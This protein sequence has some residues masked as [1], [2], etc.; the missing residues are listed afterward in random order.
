M[1]G[2]LLAGEGEGPPVRVRRVARVVRRD[3]EGE[4]PERV[5]VGQR[6]GIGDVEHRAQAAALQL[7]D[8]RVGDDDGAAPGVGDERAVRQGRELVRADQPAGRGR[9]RGEDDEDV[10]PGQERRQLVDPVDARRV[11]GR[12]AD[13]ADAERLQPPLDRA[14]DRAVADDQHASAPSR[15]AIHVRAARSRRPRRHAPRPSVR[16]CAARSSPCCAASSAPTTHSATAVSRAP[17]ALHSVA[18]GG[19]RSSIQSVPAETVCT[20]RAARSPGSASQR[21]GV[22]ADDEELGLLVAVGQRA[23]VDP[24]RRG[25]ADGLHGPRGDGGDHAPHHAARDAVRTVSSPAS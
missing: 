13:H 6:L 7:G 12:H 18:H 19:T 4:I 20:T 16:A 15:S 3:G 25:G 10:G 21:L 9:E 23:D 17:R 5:A 1:P 22:V 8:E 2:E 11:R 24:G 14:A